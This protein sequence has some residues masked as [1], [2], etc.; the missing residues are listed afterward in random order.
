MSL[1][2]VQP[3]RYQEQLAEKASSICSEFAEFDIPELELFRSRPD[4]YRMRAE[5]HVWHEGVH[6]YYRM[7]DPQTRQPFEVTSFP[8]GSETINR[9]MM[10]LIET[11]IASSHLKKRLFQVEFLTTQTNEALVS[12]IYHRQLDELW[13]EEATALQEQFGIRV[14]GRARKQK[15]V[16]DKDYVT[17]TLTV[18]GK[19]FQYTQVENSFTQPNA[20]VNEH[21]LAWAGRTSKEITSDNSS[22]LLELYCGNGNF[23]CVLA[24]YFTRVLATEMAKTSVHSA[25]ENFKL[26]GV[27]NVEIARLSSEEFTQA[28]NKERAFRRLSTIDLDSYHFSTILVDPPRAGLD[29]GTEKL[30]QNFDNIMY[31]SCNPETLKKNLST[32]CQTHR[33]E[34][35]ALFDQFPYTHHAEMGVHL[36]RK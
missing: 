21:M 6:C 35:I 1:P 20:G 27:E 16:L 36:I 18:D 10:P 26:N 23:T 34:K 11:I 29:E 25:R 4:H 7:F 31:I 15:L 19:T 9:L 13:R 30:V 28:M 22:D 14:I 24:G 8:S 33:I 32:I 17:E 3:E 2:T 5:F 12:L